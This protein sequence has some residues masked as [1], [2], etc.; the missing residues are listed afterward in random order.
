[1]GR[2]LKGHGKLALHENGLALVGGDIPLTWDLN[3]S[4]D[5]QSNDTPNA[6]P[7]NEKKKE[8]KPGKKGKFHLILLHIAHL[9][10]LSP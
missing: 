9:P 3:P 7:E 8:D 4:D 5:S 6:N 1:M 10:T 2:A